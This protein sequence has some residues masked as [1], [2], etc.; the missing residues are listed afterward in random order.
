MTSNCAKEGNVARAQ[1][2]RLALARGYAEHCRKSRQPTP[3]QAYSRLLDRMAF[4]TGL[5]MLLLVFPLCSQPFW[6]E[7]FRTVVGPVVVWSFVALVICCMICATASFI[8]GF[9][10]QCRDHRSSE[11][12]WLRR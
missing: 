3:L 10:Q 7:E 2:F 8:L 9:W 11:E 5:P 12:V 1:L 4:Y 6:A